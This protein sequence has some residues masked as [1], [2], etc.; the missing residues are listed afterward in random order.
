MIAHVLPLLVR[1]YDD[2][3]ARIQEEV[4]RRT[5]SLARQLDPPVIHYFSHGDS[6][7]L[8]VSVNLYFLFIFFC[9]EREGVR[10]STFSEKI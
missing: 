5:A 4:L 9:Y 2:T 8:N 3:D 6:K 10:D 1:A 7:F